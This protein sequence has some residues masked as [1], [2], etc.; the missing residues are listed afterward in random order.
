ML[1]LGAHTPKT[2]KIP[3]NLSQLGKILELCHHYQDIISLNLPLF[4]DSALEGLSKGRVIGGK[5]SAN[6]SYGKTILKAHTL[7]TEKLKYRNTTPRKEV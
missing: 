2:L 1:N 7:L 5:Y 6:T 3:F 4:A